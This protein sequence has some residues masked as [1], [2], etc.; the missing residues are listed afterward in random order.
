LVPRKVPGSMIHDVNLAVARMIRM[1]KE[2]KVETIDGKLIDLKP[3]SICLHGD[4]PKAVQM[5]GEMRKGLE[6][7]GIAIRPISEV[8]KA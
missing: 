2:G 5:A 3:H 4:S 1:V 6:A 7:A 8:I